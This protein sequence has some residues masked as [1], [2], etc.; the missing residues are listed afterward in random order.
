MALVNHSTDLNPLIFRC[1]LQQFENTV[2][3]KRIQIT[4]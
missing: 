1:R 3:S 4:G 2:D